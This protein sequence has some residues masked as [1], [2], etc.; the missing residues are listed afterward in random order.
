MPI[1]NRNQTAVPFVWTSG[2]PAENDTS[3][4]ERITNVCIQMQNESFPVGEQT[5]NKS[6]NA[7]DM[8]HYCLLAVCSLRVQ[9]ASVQSKRLTLS[10]VPHV[11]R[12]SST[13][14]HNKLN[15]LLDCV[16]SE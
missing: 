7:S 15:A 12:Q 14:F 3:K 6:S 16:P 5:I 11:V 9:S 1:C 13:Y 4:K 8:W 10:V 2:K